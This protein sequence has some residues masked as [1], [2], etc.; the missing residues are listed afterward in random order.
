MIMQDDY[1]YIYIYIYILAVILKNKGFPKH[2]VGSFKH[3]SLLTAVQ[4]KF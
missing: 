3:G 4:T 1:I 2:A